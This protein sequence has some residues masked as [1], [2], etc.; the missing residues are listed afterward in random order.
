[1]KNH[2]AAHILQKSLRELLGD[3]V[4]QAGAYINEHG[5]RFDFVY[6]GRLSDE[7]V[8]KTEDLSNERVDKAVDTKIEYVTL[9]EAKKR[10][11]IAL[12]E[13][14]YG[15][16]VRLVTLGDSIELCGGTHVNNTKEIGRIAI[17]SIDNKGADTYRLE[18]STDT[19]IEL[20]IN[21]DMDNYQKEAKMLL[22]KAKKILL[23]AEENNLK[24]DFN[25]SPMKEHF[26]SYKDV[27]ERKNKTEELKEKVKNLEKEYINLKQQQSVNNLDKYLSQKEEINNLTTIITTCKDT[28][29]STLKLI[30]DN[31]CNKFDNA[32]VLL[33]NINNNSVNFICKSNS[34]ND[35]IHC[36][37]IVKDLASKCE[38][39]G[40][41]SK[42]FAQ[43]GGRNATN[44][45]KYLKE[46]KES[47]KD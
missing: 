27:V 36:G 5:F 19:N 23:E 30:V 15:D 32:L 20:K 31:L 3:N 18:G 1:M 25:Y 24:L 35:N 40:G 42:N 26:T 2:S 46:I 29:V 45:D 22:S 10:G 39:N 14:K 43:G 28:D 41:G 17:S 8:C 16:I 38:G 12:F 7:M 4:H 13:D 47:L 9:D 34:T 33:A 21:E 6:H 11:A 44:I 37:N